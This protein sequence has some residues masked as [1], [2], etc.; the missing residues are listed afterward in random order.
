[1]FHELRS[2]DLFSETETAD[3]FLT[4]L[5]HL[6][7]PAARVSF[8]GLKLT[9]VANRVVGGPLGIHVVFDC[10]QQV[11]GEFLGVLHLGSAVRRAAGGDTFGRLLRWLETKLLC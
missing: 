9:V 5:H 10:V 11:Q 2:C 4:L 7:T 8:D 6:V 1:M 3:A